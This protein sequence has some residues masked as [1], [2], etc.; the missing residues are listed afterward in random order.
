MLELLPDEAL[1]EHTSQLFKHR[2][3][4]LRLCN[5]TGEQQATI[6]LPH[7][8]VATGV[9]QDRPGGGR[10]VL[11][12]DITEREHIDTRREGLIRQLAHDL[13]NPLN[14]VVGYADLVASFGPLNAEQQR[15]VDRISQT[16]QKLYDL[17]ETL[18]DL[19][20]VEAGMPLEHRP[21]AFVPQV[22]NA[23]KKLEAEAQAKQVTI[24][25]SIQD[26]VP[27]VIGDPRRIQQLIACLLENAVRYSEPNTNIAIHAWQQESKVFCTVG[28]QGIGIQADELD[29]I[30][31]RMWRS[32]DERVR[33]VPGGGIGLTFARAIVRRHGGQIWA[34]S[35]YN[36]GTTFTFVLPLAED[37]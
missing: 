30:W 2:P 3:D 37:W 13:R 23:I 33:R 16:T 35:E 8:R 26:S 5:K 4:L 31:D 22:R 32:N 10:I 7:K 9:G 12:H 34:E 21:V 15:F 14:A 17:A 24:V 6:A 18:V 29:N 25:F 20:W 27:T 11:L 19:A 28:D 1:G 36:T